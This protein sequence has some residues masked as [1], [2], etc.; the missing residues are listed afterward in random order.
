VK[1]V[2][3]DDFALK[4][5]HT[6]GTIM[7]DL[8][9]HQVVDL[10]RSRDGKEVTIW[11]KTFPNLEI[12]S[13]DGSITYAHSIAEAHPKAIQISDRFHLLQNLTKY[14]TEFFKSVLK[15]N[16]KIPV[17]TLK[18][19]PPINVNNLN[20]PFT[21]K[22]KMANGLMDNSYTFHQI[23][24]ALQMDIRTVKKVLSMSLKEQ[25]EYLMSA[26]K[27]SHEHK[28]LQKEKQI[29]EVRQM[30]KQGNSKRFIAR[31]LGL[32]PRTISKYLNPKTTGIHASLGQ[33]R[34]SILDPYTEEIKRYVTNRYTSVQVDAILR[35]KGY[36]GSASTVSHYISK[37][38]KTL[39]VDPQLLHNTEF[40]FV[41][42]K[43][44]IALLFH[45]KKTKTKLSEEQIKEIYKLYPK[46]ESVIDLVDD[47]RDILKQKRN[48]ALQ[49]WIER[50]TALD[51]QPLNSFINGIER[52]LTA[53]KNAIAYEYSNGLAEG[54]INKLKLVKRTMY[55]R[56]LFDLLRNK[57]LLLEYEKKVLFN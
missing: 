13:R 41:K 14:C 48:D 16:V 46:I 35:K 50:A 18:E 54:K 52:D 3:I 30:Y 7:V 25:E 21:E 12:V 4:K 31:Q 8:D 23:A 29:C 51:I 6:Y 49:G 22:V 43:E 19:A 37:L 28:M 38:K 32:D 34:T 44:I 24:K 39:F 2:C 26:M 55:G 40:E 33:T 1:R 27:I 56:C 53:V 11:L 10:I 20:M 5:R 47:F 57:M 9:T 42:R 36:K 15:V 45:S 17:T